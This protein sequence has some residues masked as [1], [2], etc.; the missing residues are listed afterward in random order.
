MFTR[1]SPVVIWVR[2]PQQGLVVLED[3]LRTP[4]GVSYVLE[5]RTVMLRVVPDLFSSRGRARR[6]RLSQPTHGHVALRATGRQ[7]RSAP[8]RAA[9]ARH[10][11]LGLLR[12]LISEQPDGHSLVEGSDLTVGD[13]DFVYLRSTSDWSGST[14]STDASTMTS[15]PR[16][17][18]CD[19][20][21]GRAGTHALLLQRTRKL[22]Q[23]TRRRRRR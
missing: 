15:R 17:L 1:T 4:S 3:N 14:S 13:D 5:N 21:L 8:S 6:R 7:W 10:L 11:Q 2:D 20:M 12:A 22:G 16:G 19:S 23:C 18:P 9:H